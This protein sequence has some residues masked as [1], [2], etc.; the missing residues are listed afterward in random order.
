MKWSWKVG[1]FAGIEFR[2]H[3]T[4]LLL[5]IW[6]A[7]NYWIAAGSVRTM[8][9][10]MVFI[11]ALF[12]CI[13]L[14]EMGH[15]LAARRYGIKT[16][17][18]TLLP[19]G[20]I[21]RLERMPEEPGQE[22][23][24]A[25]AGP[26]V[27]AIIAIVLYGW[28]IAEHQWESFSH[29]GLA[30]GPFVERLWAAN[31]WLILFNLIPAFPMDGGRVLRALL[32]ARTSYGKATQSAARVGQGIAVIFCIIGLF[33]NPMWIVIGVFV[34]LAATQEAASVLTKSALTG[35][36]AFAAMLTKFETLQSHDRLSEAV[37]RTLQGTQHDLPVLE[38]DRVVGM[39]TRADLLAALAKYGPDREV[40]FVMRREFPVADAVE[41]LD[42]VIGRLQP[43]NQDAVAV[44]RENRLVGLITTEKLNEYLLIRTLLEKHGFPAPSDPPIAA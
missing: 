33:A 5:L 39:L 38:H 16:K 25:L 37:Y 43:G 29:L 12:A 41:K 27:N 3:T 32:A 15:A 8:L 14:H 28:L 13:V 7:A 40:K 30:A 22:L 1:Q 10:G 44:F 36:P 31:G 9:A 11:L 23:L 2:V 34:W 19:I 42:R 18:I 35:T 21:A 17:D 6:F 24:I 20:G 26:A 4:F